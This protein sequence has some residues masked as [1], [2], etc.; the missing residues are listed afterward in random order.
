MSQT[1]SSLMLSCLVDQLPQIYTIPEICELYVFFKDCLCKYAANKLK[2]W[3]H[4]NIWSLV[5]LDF[6]FL[7]IQSLRFT[8]ISSKKCS[9]HLHDTP[10]IGYITHIK[11][12]YLYRY[13]AW[14]RSMFC[15]VLSQAVIRAWHRLPWVWEMTHHTLPGCGH[16]SCHTGTGEMCPHLSPHT[17]ATH[18]TVWQLSRRCEA[19][20]LAAAGHDS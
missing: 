14:I 6:V 12:P 4:S 13:N 10:S 3:C 20:Q 7:R 2:R 18:R 19:W 16:W 1:N 5:K 17:L 8:H 11:S 15:S 9:L